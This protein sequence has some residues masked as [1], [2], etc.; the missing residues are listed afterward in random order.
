MILDPF[1]ISGK[2]IL[3]MKSENT[4]LTSPKINIEKRLF[5]LTMLLVFAVKIYLAHI[6]P[7]TGD[8]AEYIY[9]A[10]HLAWGYYDHPPMIA[11]LL[12]PL[13]W[14]SV[15]NVWIRLPQILVS[16]IIGYFI[17][18][19][20]RP[21]HEKNAYLIAVLYLLSP[22]S[23]FNIAILTDTPLM[24]FTFLSVYCLFLSVQHEKLKYY[25]FC[26]VFIGAAFF[27]KYLMFPVAL[28][29]LLFFIVSKNI[30]HKW[31]KFLLIILFTLPFLIQNVWWNYHHDWVNLLFNL[32]LRNKSN[33]QFDAYKFLTYLAFIIFLYSPIVIY[34]TAV[35]I[36]SIYRTQKNS[37]FSVLFITAFT[38][39]FFYGALSFVKS[40]GLH[41]IFCAFPFLFMLLFTILNTSVL[42][43]CII[44]MAA[45][46]TILLIP[47]LIF[48][49]MPICI[50]KHFPRYFSKINLFLNYHQIEPQIKP[51]LDKRFILTTPSYAQ[52]YLL[53]YRQKINA[54]VW[55][56][57]SV[58]G[59]QDDL[60]N[61]FKTFNAKNILIVDVDRKLKIDDIKPYFNRFTINRFY[62]KGM[63]YC[64]ILGYGFKYNRYKKDVLRK[65]YNE[66]YQVP[67]WLPRATA[68]YKNKYG[69]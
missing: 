3:M 68:F 12:H 61:D 49:N 9:M 8:E 55:G 50:W 38:T 24:L 25:I 57:G 17:C 29:I 54:A 4:L 21:H 40:I 67:Y 34:Y 10:Q 51:F 63:P 37:A 65:I 1:D 42:K 45:Y 62:L 5:W 35:R 14:V 15:S 11:W 59:R 69:F 48:F 28:G 27:S 58:H 46:S 26:G 32:D 66:Y 52:S 44:F 56:K 23:F 43:K 13:T 6:V 18:C 60:S 30:K 64:V 39:L 16:T 7:I 36:K 19:A 41:W 33:T 31:S 22:V 53:A 20:L 47:I 2:L